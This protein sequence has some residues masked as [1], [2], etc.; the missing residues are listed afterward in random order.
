MQQSQPGSPQRVFTPHNAP[1]KDAKL[2]PAQAPLQVFG[3]NRELGSG[4][5]ALKAGT[6]IFLYGPPGVGKTA[7]AAVL[8]AA[9]TAQNPGGVLWF[10]MTE[11]DTDLL[12]VRV[13]RA[14][15]VNALTTYQDPAERLAV[16]RAL[17]ERNRPL[18]VLDGLTDADAVREFAR[19]T[20]AGIPLIVTDDTQ[21]AGP[22]TP[23]ALPLLSAT[24]SAQM[25]RALANLPDG[26]YNDD[27]DGLCRVLGGSPL[28]L[29]LAARH[30]ATDDVK[31]AELLTRLLSVV[32][33]G[34]S[35][36]DPQ[37]TILAV[38]YKQ[39]PAT[40]QAI[41]LMLGAAFA[42]NASTELIAD[43]SNV[44]AAQL[45]PI[46]RQLAARGLAH[47]SIAYG[48]VRYRLHESVQVYIR[49]ILQASQRL[50]AV[51]NRVLQAVVAYT[52]RHA[53]PDTANQDRLA[54]E[55]EN[56]IGAAAFATSVQQ[57]P[58]VRQLM[59]ALT[60]QAGDFI[61]QRGFQ[62][63]I[64]LLRRLLS[65]AG[66]PAPLAER[67]TNT[68]NEQRTDTALLADGRDARGDG[69]DLTNGSSRRNAGYDP[70]RGRAYR[71]YRGTAART[72]P[73]RRR[74]DQRSQVLIFNA[75]CTTAACIAH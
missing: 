18:I 32:P 45:V 48:Q 9:Y 16:V 61:T 71:V 75:D 35:V 34:V 24:D 41:F 46:M 55:M 26:T 60:Q 43:M 66:R 29:E 13:G 39:L 54:A 70:F 49:G 3:R 73:A 1:I 2:L 59:L 11:D 72:C 7:I 74:T 68:Q 37:Q 8:A 14:Y 62:P 36:P 57:E 23:I 33:Q 10:N 47:E 40:V 67:S 19:S 38:I 64:T 28:A 63:E 12:L 21:A 15:G 31:P 58:P 22:W 27:L 56:I 42:G 53:R 52:L 51:E 4:H 20:A 17:L 6:A 65:L 69:I 44:P 25:L 30:M 50:Q 5:V